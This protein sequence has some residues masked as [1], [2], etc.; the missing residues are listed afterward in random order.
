ML[1]RKL[2]YLLFFCF[3]LIFNHCADHGDRELTYERFTKFLREDTTYKELVVLF[4]KPDADIGSGIHLYVYHLKD[5]TSMWIG[6]TDR[7][8]YAYHVDEN[9]QLLKVLIE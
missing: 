3:P 1:M 9:D 7:V 8:L 2:T 5:S 6:Y 4:G